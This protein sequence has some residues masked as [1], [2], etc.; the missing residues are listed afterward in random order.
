MGEGRTVWREK[1]VERMTRRRA[2][3][4]PTPDEAYGSCHKE[5]PHDLASGAGPG[6]AACAGPGV[7]EVGILDA[8]P[9]YLVVLDAHDAI[10]IV[11]AAWRILAQKCGLLETDYA[12]GRPYVGPCAEVLHGVAGLAVQNDHAI[13]LI[14]A[15]GSH[16]NVW[17]YSCFL[18]GGER[19]FRLLVTRSQ[20]SGET[21][22]VLMYLDITDRKV[23][24]QDNQAHAQQ[25]V[26]V[27]ELGQRALSGM[28]LSLLHDEAVTALAQTL[29]V[30][31]AKILKVLPGARSLLVAGIGWT[32]GAVGTVEIDLDE[33]S[34]AG[35]T[36][37]SDNPVVVTD[38]RRETRFHGPALL[39]DH[40]VVSGISVIIRGRDGPWGILSAHTRRFRLFS[41]NDVNFL[42]SVANVLAAA[43]ERARI[44]T[45]LRQSSA[46]L[47]IAARTAH[48][49]GWSYD[50][51]ADMMFWSDE[52]CAIHGVP[53]DRTRTLQEALAFIVPSAQIEAQRAFR[54]CMADGEPFDLELEILTAQ[55]GSAWVR[56]IGTAEWLPTKGAVAQ[57]QGSYQDITEQ[58]RSQLD[59]ARTHRAL[60][61]LSRCNEALAR[62][63]DEIGLLQEVCKIAV[64]IGDYRMAFVGYPEQDAARTIRPA[65]H[66]GHKGD[67][68]LGGTFMSWS[69]A[70]TAGR[71]AAGIALRT[72]TMVFYGDITQKDL[73]IP[74]FDAAEACGYRAVLC[75]PLKVQ[76][77]IFG[78]LCLYAGEVRTLSSEEGRSLQELA[79]N[80]AFGI[81]HV[82]NESER[83]RMQ[84]VLKVAAGG[85][86]S[87]GS[88]FFERL[89]RGMVNALGADAACIA[90]LIP[91][92]PMKARVLM[93]QA[94]GK[95][96][97]EVVYELEGRPCGR[98]LE[99]GQYAV[100]DQLRVQFP[101]A[102]RL[103]SL[104]ARSYVGQRLDNQAGTP[105]GILYVVF[106]RP[107][108]S[109]HF[110][111]SAVS[112][113]AAR[114]TG[115]LS[116]QEA[117]SR[118]REQAA[119]LDKA[120]DAI[121]VYDL[122]GC[123]M[124][125]NEG[126]TRL[127]GWPAKEMLGSSLNEK[128]Y[129][130]GA[131]P[132]E[133]MGAVLAQGEWAGD[134]AQ[135]R[136]TGDAIMV[137]SRWTLVKDDD[138]DARAILNINTDITKRQAVENQL[139]QSQRLE[140]IGQ[141]TGGIAHDFNNLLT[142]ILGSADLL[143]HQLAEQPDL[144]KLAEMSRA[145][146]QRGTH[147]TRRLL[148]FARRQPLAPR[149]VDI[150]QLLVEM[151]ELLH[152]SLSEDIEIVADRARELWPAL[153]DPSQ[154]EGALLNLCINARDAMPT[155]GKLT[156]QTMNYVWD[157]ESTDRDI[158]ADPGDYVLI[159]VSDT[160][161]G[162]SPEH[163]QRVFDP[164][165]TT[166]E[167]G[168]G[169]GLGLSMVYGFVRQSQGYIRIRS[170][171]GE[172]TAV[173]MFLPRTTAHRSVITPIP[174]E[175]QAPK[176]SERI[177]LVEDNDLVRQYASRQLLDLGY[178]I[179]SV[180][181]ANEALRQLQNGLSVALL[182]T[183][184]VMPGGMNGLELA[185]RACVLDPALKVLYTSGYT[186]TALTHQGY[187]PLKLN[188]LHKPYRR[189]ELARR[190]RETL[191]GLSAP[192]LE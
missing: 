70:T 15:S 2:L 69:D 158:E 27:A 84:S 192:E 154:L 165:F 21:R 168:K 52:V 175:G 75:L 1:L 112:I 171:L 87:T 91:G 62:S 32:E 152:S 44:D 150:N 39:H 9:E 104:G 140:A 43:T 66:A 191:T 149:A 124:Y 133:A 173:H 31:Y 174:R 143:V 23:A 190:I 161:C 48:I 138:G 94:D 111:Q 157:K 71:G 8:L 144:M 126:A 123:V 183:D 188:L 49:G 155:G 120:H 30:E 76:E 11:N 34:Q 153:V 110:V 146:A 26:I 96:T 109:A 156:I 181:N 136:R 4:R 166:K 12:V 135:T 189:T 178:E 127:Y 107:L 163:V 105:I 97:D 42:R 28:P 172:G 167:F 162:I 164:F 102:A 169:T 180:Q 88:E 14:L 131:P 100:L 85:G 33:S 35:F 80:L 16:K 53:S 67:I 185:E 86:A 22:T 18:E 5:A 130:D 55:G 24:E 78:V 36:L 121:I 29:D 60:H 79:A 13:A 58:K 182:F 46:L 20:M 113:F 132:A 176:G 81:R 63:H 83:Q 92:T 99:I 170:T 25:Q 128:I 90:R 160:G 179:V 3:V 6:Q 93:G 159:T 117:D 51:R 148:A 57:I 45:S 17:E 68:F 89:V 54:S 106:R 37:S 72:G 47:H 177:L 119:L 108:E 64:E 116:R 19:W 187:G 59:L 65:A 74:C 147:L 125:W 139:K 137:E 118:I 103:L 184:I 95:V 61:M 115:E 129:P 10:L 7:L 122:D 151:D 50:P 73:S 98:V 142:V 186:E 141:L 38:L 41:R 82:R 77:Q 56:A 134:V 114:A 101:K 145:A 40:G